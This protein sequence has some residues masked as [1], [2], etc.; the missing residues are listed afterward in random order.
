VFG[1]MGA[2][3]GDVISAN[4]SGATLVSTTLAIGTTPMVIGG[5][6]LVAVTTFRVLQVPVE[7]IVGIEDDNGLALRLRNDRVLPLGICQP[8]VAQQI[9]G[10]GQHH[11]R[12]GARS[13]G[14]APHRVDCPPPTNL[15]R[16]SS[17]SPRRHADG[18]SLGRRRG[19]RGARPVVI[20]RVASPMRWPATRHGLRATA[21]AAAWF[22]RRGRPNRWHQ[23]GKSSVGPVH[24]QSS[25]VP[26]AASVRTVAN[27]LNM[28]ASAR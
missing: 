4:I 10:G 20:E 8:S 2:S 24:S 9:M 14:R 19:M 3:T 17:R 22:A 6:V 21:K 1:L 28:S 12:L 18:T 11:E 15:H 7:A 26:T 13:T 25:T 5:R 23:T 16:C 27:S